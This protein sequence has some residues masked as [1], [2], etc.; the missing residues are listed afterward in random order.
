MTTQPKAAERRTGNRALRRFGRHRLAV[1]SLAILL[2][3]CLVAVLA[4]LLAPYNPYDLATSASGNIQFASPPSAEFWLGTDSLGRDLLSRLIYGTRIS[5][6]IGLSSALIALVVGATLG[7]IAGYRGGLTDTLLS[8]FTDA[9]AAFP[10]LFLILTISSFVKPSI[11]NVVAII[12]LL[13]WVPTFRLMRGEALK[14]KR[15]EFVEAA[16]ALGAGESRI[17]WRH[18][19][20]NAVAPIIVQATLGVAEAILTESALSF[21]GLGVQQPIASWGN[22]LSDARDITVLQSQ[23]WLWLPPGAAIL[24]TVLAINFLGDGLRDTLNPRDK[25]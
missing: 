10:S 23:P 21:L 25:H 3:L 16:G 9:V 8:R 12:G 1:I 15:L 5:L 11:F 6:T 17:M 4:P 22:M 7:I 20:P 13:S 19:L 14:L 24:I 2:L 18:I